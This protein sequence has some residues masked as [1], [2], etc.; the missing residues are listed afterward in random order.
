MK[1][2]LCSKKEFPRLAAFLFEEEKK[3]FHIVCEL[4]DGK[5]ILFPHADIAS[6]FYLSEH[7][8][9]LSKTF[10]KIEA[11]LLCKRTGELYLC[12]YTSLKEIFFCEAHHLIEGNN[13]SWHTFFSIPQ[14]SP[15]NEFFLRKKTGNSLSPIEAHTYFLMSYDFSLRLSKKN[16][17]DFSSSTF[18]ISFNHSKAKEQLIELH[19][20]YLLAEV[21]TPQRPISYEKGEKI[22]LS[23]LHHQLIAGAYEGGKLIG[24]V[25]TNLQG[26]RAVQLG[27]IF[28]L[29]EARKKGVASALL[30]AIIKRLERYFDCVTLFVRQENLIAQ[31]V[32][33]KAGFTVEESLGIYYS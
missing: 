25:N 33:Q 17:K 20:Q 24:K 12:S 19:T 30:K 10:Q 21:A 8:I 16:Q 32:Y 27:G 6:L 3:F 2:Y 14:L 15:E 31:K 18:S 22:S 29:P 7:P 23:M 13:F 4:F 1:W 28:T 26:I 9:S 5:R 11:V